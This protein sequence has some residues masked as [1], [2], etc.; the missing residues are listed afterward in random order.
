MSITTMLIRCIRGTLDESIHLGHAVITDAQGKILS[1]IGDPQYV[2]FARS[3]AKPLQAI[4]LIESG[5][6]HQYSL[7]HEEIA[8]ICASHNGENP[9]IDAVSSILNKV[10]MASSD[11]HC[12]VHDP[13]Y[14][15][16][17]EALQRTGLRPSSLHNNC[18]GKHAGMLMLGRMLGT[19]LV[20]Y[21]RLEHP[22][23]LLILKTIAAICDINVERIITGVDGC[24]VPVFGL[25][26]DRLAV[27]FAKLGTPPPSFSNERANA[28]RTIIKALRQCPFHLGGTDRFD[29]DLIRVTDGR[30]I[31]KMGA[32]GIY[33]FTVPDH[34]IG[35][36]I[37]IVDG[38][39]RAIYPA[40]VEILQQLKLLKGSE[41]IKLQSYHKP[42][43]KNHHGKIVGC[44]EPDFRLST[45]E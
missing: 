32:E 12:G 22:V 7:S 14:Q 19:A 15:P 23:Q 4:P 34:N 43:L 21:E 25:P 44:I 11:L 3:A 33:A 29:T 40:V 27:G 35:A 28:C 24:G 41:V 39:K 18:S 37:K 2:T 20:Y 42:I 30:I 13:F 5:A 16:A 38:A 10:G 45:L 17:A 1:R 36:A 8:V 6:V 31:G 9:H 26:L